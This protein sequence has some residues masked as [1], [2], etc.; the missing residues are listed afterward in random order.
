M[1]TKQLEILSLAIR[2]I[3]DTLRHAVFSQGQYEALEQAGNDLNKLYNMMSLEAQ[4]IE[5]NQ[6]GS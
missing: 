4:N 5:F 1:E 3:N 2:T 6:Q